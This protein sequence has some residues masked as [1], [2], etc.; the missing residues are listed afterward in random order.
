MWDR[1]YFNDISVIGVHYVFTFL[2]V[3]SLHISRKE[4]IYLNHDLFIK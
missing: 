1:A 4:K 2:R 3:K